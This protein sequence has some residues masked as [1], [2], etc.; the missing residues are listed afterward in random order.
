MAFVYCTATLPQPERQVELL[1]NECAHYMANK[2]GFIFGYSSRHQALNK[3]KATS[4]MQ[5][6]LLETKNQQT[7]VLSRDTLTDNCT[8]F[9]EIPLSVPDA[10][11]ACS[12]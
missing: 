8:V 6:C 3:K 4:T 9:G 5:T 11:G 2:V 12:L 1:N 10:L 7:L